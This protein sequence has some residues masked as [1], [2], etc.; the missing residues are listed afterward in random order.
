MKK[1]ISV[2]LATALL[3]SV[4]ANCLAAGVYY[5]PDVTKE[6]SS[7]S[8]WSEDDEVLMTYEEILRANENIVI[9]KGT[10]VIDLRTTPLTVD[11]FEIN[12]AVKSSSQADANY[13]L[14]WTYINSDK[15]ATQEDFDVFIENTQNANPEKEQD[16]LFGVA[17]KRTEMR[18]FP[19]DVPIWDDPTDYEIDYQYLVGVR[20]NEPV[21]ITSVSKDG[22]YYLA[23]G[24]ACSGW[25]P[26]EAIAICKDKDEWLDAWDI[27]PED[28]FVVWGDKV[29]TEVSVSGKETS[30]LMLPL[31]TVL[32]LAKDIDP[33]E[34]ID[35]RSAYNNYVVWMPIRNE[36][37]SYAEKLTL[38]SEHNDV[39][40]GYLPL[41]KENIA[42][43]ALSYLGNTYGWGAGLKSEDCSSYVRSIYNCF[44][45]ELAR[46][47]TWQAAMP[48]PK[49]DMQYMC[50]EE[51]IKVL[52]ALPLGT[53]LCFD[54]H[55]MLY[56][57]ARN[58]KYYV[59][60]ATGS[61]MRP[62]NTSV[63]QRVRS[64][65][66]NTL[67]IKRANGNTWMDELTVALVPYYTDDAS[68]PAY[69]WY[70]D[71]VAFCL[72][73][74]LMQGDENKFFNPEQNITWAEFLQI[75]YNREET[76]KESGENA[77]WY[78]AAVAWAQENELIYEDD[79]DF[80]PESAITR[81]QLAS[82][83]YLYAQ[84]KGYDVSV[85]EETNI[86]SYDDAFEISE[87]AIPAIQYVAGAGIINGKTASTINPKDNTTRAEIAVIL[88]RFIEKTK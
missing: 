18:V 31:G 67:D 53:I 85:G 80:N 32:K 28:A 60:S 64:T 79:K 1:I 82:V 8:Y 62:E 58:G 5:L 63:R 61:I 68:M 38:I 83:L 35:N 6:M 4:S 81:E 66:I 46:N 47:A 78:A 3:L 65:I 41:T 45:L 29:Y 74:K 23:R 19:S 69:E 10:N 84:F 11:G 21:Y 17:V 76:K 16:V 27:A 50:K 57:G 14:G 49:I 40:A 22:K 86:L 42:K 2:F 30:E 44:G 52:E 72:K 88:Q 24:N 37:G 20:V 43:V 87:Y 39:S 56:L 15:L 73:N 51:R 70:H 33:N 9:Q 12:E 54:G 48:M 13:Y 71:G 36:D 55:E 75:L 34:L 25:V 77:E 26:V 59:I 7:P